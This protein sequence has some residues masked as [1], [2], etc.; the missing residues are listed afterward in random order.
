MASQ[1]LTV[2]EVAA[3]LRIGLHQAYAFVNSGVIRSVKVGRVI[4]V[5]RKALDEFLDPTL[6][7]GA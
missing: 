5:P 7:A 3:E 2:Q 6:K 1:V 4:R